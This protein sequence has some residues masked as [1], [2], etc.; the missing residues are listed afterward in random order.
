MTAVDGPGGPPG[1]GAAVPAGDRIAH[2]P[3]PDALG[4]PAGPGAER[5][6]SGDADASARG[7]ARP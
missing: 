2:D 3:D 5:A 6:E 7:A 4:E 1:A